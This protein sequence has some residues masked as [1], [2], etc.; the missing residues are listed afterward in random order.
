[1]PIITHLQRQLF[2][3]LR[4]GIR[5]IQYARK[6]THRIMA[7]TIRRG[8]RYSVGLLIGGW[9]AFAASRCVQYFAPPT[10]R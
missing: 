8:C 3:S 6:L 2:I 5:T 7:R 1:M 9:L 4:L 10:A